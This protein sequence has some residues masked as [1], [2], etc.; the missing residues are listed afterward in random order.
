MEAVR[1]NKVDLRKLERFGFLV[2]RWDYFD[3]PVA[4]LRPRQE[5]CAGIGKVGTYPA[6]TI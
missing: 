4:V 1:S 5:K 2:R 6:S 3:E